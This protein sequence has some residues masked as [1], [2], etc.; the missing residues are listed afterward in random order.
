MEA[1]SDYLSGIKVANLYGDA[2]NVSRLDRD[3]VADRPDNG[4]GD[5]EQER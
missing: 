4:N 1:F 3:R 5:G 2:F